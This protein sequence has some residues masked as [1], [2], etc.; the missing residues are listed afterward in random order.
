MN[1]AQHHLPPHPH[2]QLL[3]QHVKLHYPNIRIGSDEDLEGIIQE[4]MFDTSTPD[5][6][7]A[8]VEAA[9]LSAAEIEMG[10]LFRE[11]PNGSIVPHIPVLNLARLIQVRHLELIFDIDPT[12]ENALHE[13][14]QQLGMA[15]AGGIAALSEWFP[16]LETLILHLRVDD[17]GMAD[18]DV[19]AAVGIRSEYGLMRDILWAAYHEGPGQDKIFSLSVGEM[20]SYDVEVGALLSAS[21]MQ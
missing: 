17:I 13:Q 12:N 21:D 19:T 1:A 3:K 6:L 14:Y 20:R 8:M 7:R 11:K 4:I 18:E 16:H 2:H 10:I 9:V 5:Q 15:H